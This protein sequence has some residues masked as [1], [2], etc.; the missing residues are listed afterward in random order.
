MCLEIKMKAKMSAM[1]ETHPGHLA[2]REACTAPTSRAGSPSIVLFPAFSFS[3][4]TYLPCLVPSAKTLP[5]RGP[6]DHPHFQGFAGRTHRMQKSCPTHHYGCCRGWLGAEF[7]ALI[8]RETYFSLHR[9]SSSYEGQTPAHPL[10][11]E[12][13]LSQKC[14]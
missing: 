2:E 3:A 14:T 7:A 13:I 11:I 10:Y 4:S 5:F 6:Q 12:A 1:D 8:G 9:R